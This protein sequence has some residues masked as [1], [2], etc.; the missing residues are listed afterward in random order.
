MSHKLENCGC[1]WRHCREHTEMQFVGCVHAQ[2]LPSCLTLCDPGVCSPPG[3][4]VLGNL[5][6][7]VLK[8][9]AMPS[10]KGSSRPRDQTHISYV[11][12]IGRAGSLFT[13]G[14]TWETLYKHVLYLSTSL[15]QLLSIFI[16]PVACGPILQ[17]LQIL[18]CAVIPFLLPKSV[19]L[20]LL[21]VH[22]LFYV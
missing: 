10:F 6:A 2:S 9:I 22:F 18:P 1:K 20:S 4:S 21:L 13:I 8:W 19:S 12:C 7:R 17:I 16:R 15:P 11:S 3:S 14:A 5:Q